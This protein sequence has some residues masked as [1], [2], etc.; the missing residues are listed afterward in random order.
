[1]LGS[2]DRWV[3]RLRGGLDIR[4]TEERMDFGQ[5]L[6]NVSHNVRLPVYVRV[7]R[8]LYDEPR[9]CKPYLARNVCMWAGR[10]EITAS[11]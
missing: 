9:T 10:L 3:V 7:A 8:L 5:M 4:T 11:T 6:L 2:K 1:M